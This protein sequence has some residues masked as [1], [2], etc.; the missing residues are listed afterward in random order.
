MSYRSGTGRDSQTGGQ[1]GADTLPPQGRTSMVSARNGNNRIRGSGRRGEHGSY[2]SMA[3]VAH[4]IRCR[5]LCAYCFAYCLPHPYL[6]Y[7]RVKFAGR[8]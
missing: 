4:C 8:F 7:M 3:L 5:L 1:H 6:A 2:W